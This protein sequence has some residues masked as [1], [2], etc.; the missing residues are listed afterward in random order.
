MRSLPLT[1]VR[2]TDSFWSQWQDTVNQTTLIHIH[3]QIE[4]TGRLENFRKVLRGESGN[5]KGYKF[6]DSDVYKWLEACAYSLA[7]RPN[8]EV[9]RVANEAMELVAQTQEPDGYINTFF[10]LNYPQFKWANLSAMH[11]MYCVGH[12][13]EACVAMKRYLNHD[14][15][16]QVGVRAADHVLSI[17]GPEGR[18]GY[19]GHEEIELALIKL[20]DITGDPKY[21]ERARWMVDVRGTRPSPFEEELDTEGTK[22]MAPWLPGFMCV[23]GKYSGEY[24]QD[25]APVREHDKV[26]GH[27]VRAM[28]LYIAAADLADG[29]NDDAMENALMRAWSNLTKRRMYITGGIGPSGSNEGFTVDYDLPNLSSYAET[30]AAIG[31]FLWGHAMLEQTGESEYADVMEQALYNG[32]LSGMSLSGDLFFYANPHESHGTHQ[33]V[34]WFGCACCPPNIARVLAN[35]GSYV[36]GTS[37]FADD[38]EKAVWIHIPAALHAEVAPGVRL[39]I[40]GDFPRSGQARVKIDA[41]K[42]QAFAIKMRIP[43]W[44]QNVDLE[45]LDVEADYDGGYMV[46][47]RTWNPGDSFVVNFEITPRWV[48]SNPKV[49]ANLGRVALTRGPLVYCLQAEKEDRT[50]LLA[51]V[52][53][54]LEV[55][56]LASKEFNGSVLLKSEGMRLQE[57]EDEELYLDGDPETESCELNFIPYYAWCNPGPNT[58]AVWL[59]EE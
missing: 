31:L 37:G 10:Q 18:L 44:C 26:V 30:C 3:R 8:T 14:K 43:I 54:D 40:E 4:E 55:A 15:F 46:I 52:N 25:H 59:R 28:Y 53:P 6:D 2:I 58:M 12:L 7:T 51:K 50:P 47:R 39:T 41:D 35:L 22:V 17:F 32:L 13:I 42:P 36:V 5:H 38:G 16:F 56:E 27:A 29:Q 49:V 19:C 21:R 9:E 33:R 1:S 20:S 11:E 48:R 45:G 34:P 24:A 57:W 23:D